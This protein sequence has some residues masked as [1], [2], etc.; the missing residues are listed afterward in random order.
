VATQQDGVL[1][2]DQLR[3]QIDHDRVEGW[4]GVLREAAAG[5]ISPRI[6]H[7]SIQ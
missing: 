5:E 1:V 7:G 4:R 3:F 2:A 6:V